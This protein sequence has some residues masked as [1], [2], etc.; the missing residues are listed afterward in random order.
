VWVAC[1]A[2]VRGGGA[3]GG[4]L[5][6]FL[7]HP[8]AYH[9]VVEGPVPVAWQPSLLDL[10]ESPAVD[11]SYDGLVRHALDETSWVDYCP[12]WLRGHDALFST[13]LA[14]GDW[15]QRERR[16]YE[17]RVLEPRL[18]AGWDPDASDPSVPAALPAMC[19]ALSARYGVAFDRVWVNLYRDGRDSVAWHPDRNGRVHLNP[20]V[21]TVSLGARRRFQ[22]R[23]RGGG[24]TVLTLSPGGGDLVVMGGAC[25]HDWEHCVPKTA[26]P[27][28]PRMS[29]TIRHSH[30]EL[31]PGKSPGRYYGVE[32]S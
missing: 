5:G 12:G 10:G 23:P 15:Q 7:S 13:L 4:D 14:T 11:V 8:R 21:A 27:V 20:L 26:R 2:T 29:V 1:G 6:A 32:Y 17:G 30:G 31:L 19:E 25:Q 28:G 9:V 18:T 16:M 22:L 3:L 24:R